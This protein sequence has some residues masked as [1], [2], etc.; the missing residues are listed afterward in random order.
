MMNHTSKDV[1]HIFG[2]FVLPPLFALGALGN[3][4]IMAYFINVNKRNF[5]T[6]TSY[7]YLIIQIAF[8]DCLIC[9]GS[10]LIVYHYHSYDHPWKLKAFGCTVVYP[11]LLHICP[12]ISCWSLVLL[13]YERYHG[14][15]KPFHKSLHKKHYLLLSVLICFVSAMFLFPIIRETRVIGQTCFNGIQSFRTSV[16]VIYRI[17]NRF[18]DCFIPAALM[19]YFYRKM[20]RG[21]KMDAMLNSMTSCQRRNRLALKTLKNLILVYVLCVFPGRLM[22]L[23][24]MVVLQLVQTS[25]PTL[26][27]CIHLFLG[28]L[29]TSNNTVN[30]FVYARIIADFRRFLRSIVTLSCLRKPQDKFSSQQTRVHEL[31]TLKRIIVNETDELIEDSKI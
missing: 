8:V 21:L 7:H 17:A 13:S 9:V 25:D 20:S 29:Y 22:V 16:A 27:S 4:L 18:L 23:I 2:S 26:F 19:C 24:Q 15:S 5:K 10:C 31:K 3:I 28:F 14:I 6:M 1:L 12:L 30:V 11:V